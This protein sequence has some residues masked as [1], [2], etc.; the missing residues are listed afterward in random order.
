MRRIGKKIL[1]FLCAVCMLF[2]SIGDLGFY[3][4]A[5]RVPVVLTKDLVASDDRTYEITVSFEVEL[6]ENGE[7]DFP[8]NVE[9]AV[10]ELLAPAP[11]PAP[12]QKSA[13]QGSAYRG[14]LAQDRELEAIFERTYGPT[15]E[16][17]LRPTVKSAESPSYE[18][19]PAPADRGPEY[20]L[21]DGYN[22]IFAWDEL[23][24]VARDNLDAARQLLMDLLVN[25]RGYRGCELI[26][27]FDAY[28]VPR[29]L[30]EV[31]KYHNI[32]VVYTKEAET[33]DT[34]IEKTSYDLAKRHRV[35]VATSDNMEQLIILGH[36]SL[37]V[38]AEAF[39][40]EVEQVAGQISAI[41]RE[42]LKQ[43]RS[44]PLADAMK[45]AK[46]EKKQ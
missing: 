43:Q 18:A 41:L 25:Y 36:G 15:K 40:A 6:D 19:R 17:A 10:R 46:E 27:V 24:E 4:F 32:S 16:R 13:P 12:R 44:Q 3:A 23:K 8:E 26:L 38:S 33:A 2:S 28:R 42:S 5:A 11:E 20:L 39:H 35:R 37:R 34:Y 9:L 30:G 22:I 14:S 7:P 45:R 21:V 1:S 31:V 29:N